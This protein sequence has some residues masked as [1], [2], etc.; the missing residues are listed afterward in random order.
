MSSRAPVK[1]YALLILTSLI[2]AGNSVAG[3]IGVGH[4]DPILL[5]TLRWWIAAIVIVTLSLKP[6]KRDWPVI[7]AHWPLLLGYGATGFALF[8]ILLYSALTQTAAVNVMIEQ[9]GIPL[10]I[11]L[12]NFI[13]FRTRATVAQLI[14]FVL[15]VTGVVITATHGD[16][17]QLLHL[18]LNA[19]DAMMLLAILVYGGYTVS[20]KWKPPLH[21]QSLLAIPCAGAALTCLPFLAWRYTTHPFTAPDTT[22]WGVVLYAAIL[23]ALVASATYIAGIELIGANRAGL[24]INLLPIFGVFL[25]VLILREPLH[26]FHVIAL[27]LVSAG[28]VLSE[29]SRL[30][31]ARQAA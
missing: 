20:L 15:T 16:I 1:A 22:G 29:W 17:H 30:R 5:T 19:G 8:N 27:I 2:W 6:L 7:K 21:W 9:A 10:I 23:V 11:F 31:P 18:K 25:A 28:I 13:L 26:S 24:F 4:V 3:K 12:G 14:G